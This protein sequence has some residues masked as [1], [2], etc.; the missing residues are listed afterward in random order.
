MLNRSGHPREVLVFTLPAR[1][2]IALRGLPQLPDVGNPKLT[3]DSQRRPVKTPCTWP[4]DVGLK[5]CVMNPKLLIDAIVRQTTVLVAQLSTTA[6]LRSPLAHIADQVFLEL[7]RELEEQGLGKKIAADMF[8]MALRTYQVKV[9][10]LAG[11]ATERD[12]TLWEAII[13]LLEQRGPLLRREIDEHFSRDDPRSV[14]AILSDLTT[15]GFVDRDGKGDRTRYQLTPKDEQRR[16]LGAQDDDAAAM[17]VWVGI[18]RGGQSV[19]A[20]EQQ[21]GLSRDTIER[22]VATLDA[23]GRLS[24]GDQGELR[25]TGVIVPLD[26][27]NGWEAAVF[28]HYQ[29]LVTAVGRRLSSIGKAD[30]PKDEEGGGTVTFEISAGHPMRAQVVGQLKN[31]REQVN[32][33][34]R[35][36]KA[37]NE[38]HPEDIGTPE[39]V[40]VYFGQSVIPEDSPCG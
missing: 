36:V 31:I 34:W 40:T 38:A 33:L 7:S 9:Q 15:T 35:E 25:T 29:A 27:A 1:R 23:Q 28:D 12:R 19:A 17:L 6:G 22:A 10:R 4:A 21:L 8:G 24:R 2:K 16:R 14:G 11:S 20:L 13:A 32:D 26:A 37:Y 18:Y 5:C 39:R 30:R 3:P